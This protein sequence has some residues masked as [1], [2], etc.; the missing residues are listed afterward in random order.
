[1]WEKKRK[2]NNDYGEV[3][4]VGLKDT[5]YMESE[6]MYLPAQWNIQYTFSSLPHPSH[7][8]ILL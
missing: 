5:T 2:H 7:G 3:I 4:Q 8:T 6:Q 1:M